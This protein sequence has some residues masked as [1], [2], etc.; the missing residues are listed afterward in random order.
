M[1]FWAAKCFF[2]LSECYPFSPL[3]Y[4][5]PRRSR[6]IFYFIL[7]SQSGS[8]TQPAR[9]ENGPKMWNAKETF[10]SAGIREQLRSEMVTIFKCQL[11]PSWTQLCSVQP[12][13]LD[14]WMLCVISE[15][16]NLS[17]SLPKSLKNC[18]LIVDFRAGGLLGSVT[19]VNMLQLSLRMTKLNSR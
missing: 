14:I 12:K 16:L 1:F 13:E 2:S 5:N 17:T 11:Q 15:R 10:L 18:L 9:L 19:T 8:P 4:G 6:W 7:F 3:T